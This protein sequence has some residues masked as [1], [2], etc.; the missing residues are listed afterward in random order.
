MSF[1]VDL[2]CLQDTESLAQYI[3][4]IVKVGDVVLLKGNL[5]SGKTT[6]ARFFVDSLVDNA[7]VSSP[8]FSLVNVYEGS[9]CEIWHYDLYRVTHREE[10]HELGIDD[11]LSNAIA[12]IEWPELIEGS[13]SN[14]GVVVS[15]Q[16][17]GESNVREAS[18]T[19]LGKFSDKAGEVNSFIKGLNDSR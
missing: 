17:K 5:G 2:R 16:S 4:S 6:F 18:L 14:D 11:A 9:Q 8:T 1:Q 19:L 10:L 7:H 15:L 3:A 13:I 12:I